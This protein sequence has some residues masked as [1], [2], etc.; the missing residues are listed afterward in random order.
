MLY[1][2]LL[3]FEPQDRLCHS[4]NLPLCTSDKARGTEQRVALTGERESERES[5]ETSEPMIK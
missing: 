1:R 4:V 3:R 2:V 5:K